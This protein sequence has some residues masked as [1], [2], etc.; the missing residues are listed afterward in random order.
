MDAW[1]QSLRASIYT[2]SRGSATGFVWN[3]IGAIGNFLVFTVI[4]APPVRARQPRVGNIYG[5]GIF[6]CEDMVAW[7]LFVDI[8]H[9]DAGQPAAIVMQFW[10]W[11]TPFVDPIAAM[12][13][14]VAVDSMVHP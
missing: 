5:Y 13:E 4:F 7:G 14:L 2:R 9:G 3:L 12:P 10:F 6:L 1:Q 8:V 11:L